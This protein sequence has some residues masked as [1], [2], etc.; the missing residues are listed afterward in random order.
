MTAM[1]NRSHIICFSA[2]TNPELA[3]EFYETMLGLP[4]VEASAFALVFDAGGTMLR[5]QIVTEHTPAPHTLLGW[6]VE[7]IERT[8]GELAEHGVHAEQYDSIEQSDMGVWRSPSGA[9]VAWFSDPDG[10]LLSLTQFP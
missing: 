5:V 2:T 7:D 6:N 1:L 4:L 9:C 8:L 3:R 10:N